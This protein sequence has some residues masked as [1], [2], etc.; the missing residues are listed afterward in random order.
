MLVA[1]GEPIALASSL[2]ALWTTR[3]VSHAKARTA[4]ALAA[5]KCAKRKLHFRNF[6]SASALACR[7]LTVK[8]A[9]VTKICCSKMIVM[10]AKKKNRKLINNDLS[11]AAAITRRKT[12]KKI[13]WL[14]RA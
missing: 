9:T 2:V 13:P 14:G 3:K 6:Q 4:K 1:S 5:Q 8:P 10:A 7:D 12:R 11:S